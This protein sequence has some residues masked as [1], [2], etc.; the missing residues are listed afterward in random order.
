MKHHFCYWLCNSALLTAKL[1]SINDKLK[2]APSV[3]LTFVIHPI[4]VMKWHIV[5]FGR[6]WWIFLI[7]I[8]N[9]AIY[10]FNINAYFAFLLGKPPYNC[11]F[12]HH[13]QTHISSSWHVP[14][15]V[16]QSECSVRLIKTSFKCSTTCSESA[17]LH[18]HFL[19]FTWLFAL[20]IMS[21]PSAQK[22]IKF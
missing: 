22:N 6:N 19:H 16:T 3:N 7:I 8:F 12:C 2:I 1:Y 10:Q 18:S 11:L 21:W 4:E 13:I 5:E 15:A 20:F 9:S 17:I 14:Y